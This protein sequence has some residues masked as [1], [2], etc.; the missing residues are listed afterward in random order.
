MLKKFKSAWY[1]PVASYFR[2]FASIQLMFWRPKIVVVTGSSGKTTLLHLI[3]SQIGKSAKYSHKANSAYGVPFDILG[4]KRKDLFL[5]EWFYLFL[6]AP[7]RAFKKPFKENL[8]IV[9]ADCD[10]PGEG[11]FLASLLKPAVTLWTGVSRTHSMNFDS[12]VLDRKFPSVDE[13]IS[14]EFGYFLE[15]TKDLSI[16]NG[17]SGLINNQLKRTDSTIKTVDKKQLNDYKVSRDGTIFEI[18]HQQYKIPLLLPEEV[19]YSI[20]MTKEFLEYLDFKIDPLFSNFIIPPGRSSLFKGIKQTILI[21]STYNATLDGMRAMLQM[22]DKYPSKEKW[23]VL[24]D[25]IELGEEEQEEH[26][27]L[28]EI[29]ANMKLDKII[30]I[31][32]RIS[33]YTYPKLEQNKGLEVEKFTM[34]KDGLEYLKNNLK[35]GETILFKGARFLEGIIEHLLE[36]KNDAKYLP[37]REKVWQERRTKW[38]L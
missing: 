28:A 17:D 4:L 13:A 11:K 15:Y 12:L 35:G 3:E 22:F 1:F 6:L 23:V 29:I 34:P 37:R 18:D 27:K 33:K 7:V 32:P 2:F 21:D 38:G 14:F 20:A 26:E 16:V 8:Y 25:M 9:E 5:T 30:L 10:R 31:G 19:F 36:N 24:G